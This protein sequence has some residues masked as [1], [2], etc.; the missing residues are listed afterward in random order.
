MTREGGKK[1]KIQQLY[2]D[3]ITNMHD[4]FLG[5][6]FLFQTYGK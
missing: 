1:S 2:Q 6:S 3:Y 5:G 4:N